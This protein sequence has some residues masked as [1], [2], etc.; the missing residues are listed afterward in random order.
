MNNSEFRK[1]GHELIDWIA[2]F[3]ESIEKYPVKSQLKPGQILKQLPPSPPLQGEKMSGLIQDFS[4]I[5]LP[6]ISHWQSPN[7]FA[8]FPANS[9]FP[10]ILGELL[11]AAMGVQGMVWETS[12]AASE[13]EELT[14]NWLKEMTGVPSGFHGVIQ[15]TASTST[16]VAILS[17]REKISGYSI[18]ESGFH[19]NNYRVYC[20]SEAHSSIE[21]DVKIA[22][23]G[24]KA[25]VK[26][27][28]DKQLAMD[29]AELEKQL[30][31]DI[32]KGLIPVCVISAVGT[33]G[34]A[35][36]DPVEE[37][38]RIC[39][40]FNTWH[41][42]DAAYAGSAM[43]LEE[44]RKYIKGIENA[45]SYVFN[46]HKWMFTNFDCSAYFVKDKEALIRTFEIMPEYLKTASDKQVN[47]YRDWGI[48]LGRRFRALKLW[49]V[50]REMGVEGIR[51]KIRN[52]ITWAGELAKEIRQSEMFELHEP[53]NLGLVC[54]RLKLPGI[55]TEEKNKKNA[56]LL[57]S[58][59]ESGKAYVSHT[60]VKGEYTLRMVTGQTEVTRNHVFSAWD[61]IY[62]EAQKLV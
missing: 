59:N 48:Q 28:V 52:H 31:T 54:F 14:M 40:K 34:T 26:I 21:K 6:G 55:T 22:G 25:L 57:K 9:S 33:T 43:V 36:M 35:A 46:P 2:D 32:S 50:I 17:A 15:D 37:I 45:D 29:T 53:Q 56:S 62:R 19:H 11:T 1:Y 44:N 61:L 49:F 8:Y 24:K 60:T 18:N 13:L 47:N 16:L 38:S 7:F 5:I 41:H 27:R 3:Y 39:R 4:E 20:S 12:P 23:F 42:I 10:S 58:I 30:Q 51:H